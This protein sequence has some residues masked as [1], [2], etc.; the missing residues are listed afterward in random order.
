MRGVPDAR[1]T[2][3]AKENHRHHG[4]TPQL[5]RLAPRAG[6][7]EVCATSRPIARVAKDLGIHRQALRG[8]VRQAEDDRGKR[9][10]RLAT[11]EQDELRQLYKDVAELRRANET[12]KSPRRFLPRRST[13]P[14]QAE[15]VIGHLRDRG[16]GVDPVCRVLELSPSTYFA[17]KKRPKS[18]RRLRDEQ[19]RP[20]IEE[21][22]AT[23][24]GT[25]GARRITRALRRKGHEVARCTVERPMA[26]LSLK[27]VIRGRR[28]RT[29]VAEP[30]APRPRDLVD[31]DFTASRPDQLWVADMTY[32]RTSSGWPHVAFVLD[33]YSRMNV[34]WQVANHS[35]GLIHHSDRGSQYASIRHIGR[36][37]DIDA[38]ASAARS[39]TRMTTRW[40]R[41][42]TAP[43]RPS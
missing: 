42:C 21:A 14:D 30:S 27:G 12:S 36:L 25:Y 39:Q 41:Y 32:V 16:L 34:A 6:G 28:R 10:D 40:P 37:S 2:V 7:R 33:V 4:S 38:S 1:V 5:P 17:R 9:D 18:A 35:S 13:V 15:Q 19:L 24:G 22:H 43:S 20:L 8:W 11:G 29:T 31:R 26:E 3:L 23:S